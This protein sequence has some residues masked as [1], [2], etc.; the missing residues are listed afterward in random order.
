MKRR[1]TEGSPVTLFPFLDMLMCTMGALIL[2]FVC[3]SVRMRRD[4]ADKQLLRQSSPAPAPVALAPEL[5]EPVAAPARNRTSQDERD[6]LAA[7]NAA[8]RARRREEWLRI[9][10]EARL[11][12]DGRR[13]TLNDQREKIQDFDRDLRE[14]VA[15]L[16]QLDAQAAAAEQARHAA[17]VAA[18]RMK[19][20]EQQLAEQIELAR[21]NVDL[22]ARKQAAAANEFALVPYDGTSG[23][24]R[25]PI[26]IECSRHG[27]RFLPEN[28]FI[29]VGDLQG[30]NETYNPLLV[31]AQTLAR[32]WNARRRQSGGAEPEPYVLLIVRPSGCLRYY[33]ARQCLMTLTTPFGY[34]LVEE[35]WK[36]SV[37]VADPQAQAALRDA[38]EITLEARDKSRPMT[39]GGGSGRLLDSV[40]ELLGEGG[41]ADGAAPRG[42]TG[43]GRGAG[44]RGTG[45]R[46]GSQFGDES[47]A[48]LGAVGDAAAPRNRGAARGVADGRGTRGGLPSGAE[49]L[50]PEAG[51]PRERSAGRSAART[52]QPGGSG[53]GGQAD[54]GRGDASEWGPPGQGGSSRAGRVARNGRARP[55]TLSGNS[56]D[57]GDDSEIPPFSPLPDQLPASRGRTPRVVADNHARIP[58]RLRTLEPEPEGA[59]EGDGPSASET[60][61]GR[62]GATGRTGRES[63]GDRPTTGG[64]GAVGGTGAPQGSVGVS[65]GS[66]GGG[67][68]NSGDE[69]QRGGRKRFGQSH[70]RAGIGLERKLEIH[71]HPERLLIGPGDVAIPVSRGE[72]SDQLLGK[73]LGG[74]E[75]AAQGWGAP[76]ANFYWLPAVRFIV[77]PGGS[78]HY[79][80]LRG[81]L[82]KWGVNSTVEYANGEDGVRA[83]S[84][85]RP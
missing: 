69:P 56:A 16:D 80:R 59:D 63:S 51:A 78:P 9:L 60:A 17:A 13:A 44:A 54:A 73:V 75:Q 19:S 41:L 50:E 65:V 38:I 68:G 6:R 30:F 23:T 20:Q 48:Q 26:Y 79:E 81:P 49:A 2:L 28:E 27:F 53:D 83:A 18:E 5:D 39:A 84:G 37:P 31:G 15:R 61:P 3:L 64:G 21:R 82:Q 62:T 22:A 76:P 47:G 32:Y 1:S 52:S 25:R 43:D 11:R 72:K 40:R 67:G 35:D 29:A 33:I 14:A 7:E 70:A 42:A 85:G 8:E 4:A 46:N 34:E 10:A 74:I 58:G 55:A 66:P 12:R 36:M 45:N 57:E 71:L 77:Y 24:V